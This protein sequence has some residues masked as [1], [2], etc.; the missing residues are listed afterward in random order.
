MVLGDALA[1]ALAEK[2]NFTR[3][4]FAASHPG[5]ALGKRLLV[6]NENV[7]HV[8]D[9]IPVIHVHNTLGEA[10]VEVSHKKLGFVAVLDDN[11]RLYGIFTDGDIRRAL[12]AG[13]DFRT[14]RVS[15]FVKA[16]CYT[17]RKDQ[18]AYDSL[19]LMEDKK[20]N[21]LVVIDEVN[22]VIGAFNIHDL[23]QAGIRK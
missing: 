23:I 16:G 8:G 6:H 11:E 5:G 1:I 7:M 10:I 9:E 17:V 13:F 4:D 20:I 19:I 18:M 14:T 3:N 21:A 12:T 22:R 15:E 2:N